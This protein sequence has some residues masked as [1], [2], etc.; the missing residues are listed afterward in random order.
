MP[1]VLWGC[2]SKMGIEIVHVLSSWELLGT[3]VRGRL[4]ERNRRRS[5]VTRESSLL[6]CHTWLFGIPLPAVWGI[7]SHPEAWKN[8]SAMTPILPM[9]K[10]LFYSHYFS[11]F[12]DI[13][14]IFS[15]V[16]M[17]DTLCK[18]LSSSCSSVTTNHPLTL[19]SPH[20]SLTSGSQPYFLNDRYLPRETQHHWQCSWEPGPL[21]SEMLCCSKLQWF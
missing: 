11:L 19:L 5:Q 21:P 18:H 6:F 12:S 4:V 9:H 2:E 7:R 1:S 17:E 10:L 20:P 3:S 16:G 13:S 8:D 15:G 14:P